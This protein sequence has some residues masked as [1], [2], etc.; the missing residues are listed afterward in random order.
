MKEEF[1]EIFQLNEQTFM[2]GQK[3][4]GFMTNQIAKFYRPLKYQN[5]QLYQLHKFTWICEYVTNFRICNLSSFNVPLFIKAYV[6]NT[7]MQTN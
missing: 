1:F 4:C 5:L 6:N 2:S 3:V 7:E